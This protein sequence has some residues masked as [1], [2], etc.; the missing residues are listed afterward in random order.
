MSTTR[1]ETYTIQKSKPRLNSA[2]CESLGI[3]RRRLDLVE[4]CVLEATH[5][6]MTDGVSL[7]TLEC[8]R[9]KVG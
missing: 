6:S 2:G 9:V 1:L 8:G 7:V 5:L 4:E 3:F